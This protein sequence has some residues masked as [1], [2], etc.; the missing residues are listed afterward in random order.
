M[1]AVSLSQT[2]FV[3][4]VGDDHN[5]TVPSVLPDT[6]NLSSGVLKV[7]LGTDPPSPANGVPIGWYVEV[8]QS[9]ILPSV[10]PAT[11]HG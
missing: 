11:S 8:F 3:K 4:S 9:R 2:D 7:T 5:R 1:L 10:L 6:I